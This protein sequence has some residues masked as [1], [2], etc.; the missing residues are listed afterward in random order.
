MPEKELSFKEL[1]D[2]AKAMNVTGWFSMNKKQLIISTAENKEN[3]DIYV[4]DRAEGVSE[5][6]IERARS[7]NKPVPG[8]TIMWKKDM[9][10]VMDI[11]DLNPFA[12]NNTNL[13]DETA[14][15]IHHFD[16]PRKS[17]KVTC[18]CGEKFAIQEEWKEKRISEHGAVIEVPVINESDR[19]YCPN[20][21]RLHIYHGRDNMPKPKDTY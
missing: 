10:L 3:S 2:K 11:I 4:Y 20:C 7:D 12:F 1:Q 21:N 8:K 15:V 14:P 6:D 13:T 17:K 5:K 18:A 16:L 19:R 9:D